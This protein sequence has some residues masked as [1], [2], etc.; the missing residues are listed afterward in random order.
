MSTTPLTTRTVSSPG[1]PGGAISS[2]TATNKAEHDIL[3]NF[4]NSLLAPGGSGAAA[5]AAQSRDAAQKE[6]SK[7]GK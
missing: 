7:L 1:T 2:A 3:A 4:F 5:G 6:L